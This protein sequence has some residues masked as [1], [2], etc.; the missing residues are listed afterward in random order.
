MFLR[1][2]RGRFDPNRYEEVVIALQGAAAIRRLPGY[3]SSSWGLDQASG[4]LVAVRTWDTQQQAA[5]SRAAANPADR[6]D[7]RMEDTG[8]EL[9]APEIYEV[10]AQHP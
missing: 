5:F 10:V 4:A 6:E 8:F 3:Q 9:D 7:I 1:V 2:S